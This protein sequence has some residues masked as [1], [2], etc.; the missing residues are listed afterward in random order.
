MN[1]P[2]RVQHRHDG[3]AP[4]RTMAGLLAALVA[5]GSAAVLLLAAA[6]ASA[7]RPA[8]ASSDTAP[9]PASQQT[10]GV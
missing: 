10:P 1:P 3:P 2:V 4:L 8:H 6:A 9:E 5:L 7:P